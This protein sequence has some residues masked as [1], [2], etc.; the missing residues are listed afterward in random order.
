MAVRNG[1]E[2]VFAAS[3]ILL[4]NDVQFHVRREVL[5]GLLVH[6]A[7][8]LMGLFALVRRLH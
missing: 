1:M 5:I 8:V 4:L 2:G 6:G 7:F 3:C